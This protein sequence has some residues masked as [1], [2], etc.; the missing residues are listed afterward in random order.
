LDPDLKGRGI[1]SA[2]LG[3]LMERCDREQAAVRLQVLRG[4]PARRLYERHGFT[5]ETEDEVDVYM[6][7]EPASA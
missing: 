2:V 5:A 6:V 7:R 1:G 4:S 3:L